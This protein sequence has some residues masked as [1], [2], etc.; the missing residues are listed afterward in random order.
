MVFTKIFNKSD[1]VQLKK[2]VIWVGSHVRPI[3]LKVTDSIED[4]KNIQFR[5]MKNEKYN[6]ITITEI[7]VFKQ[8]Y[9]NIKIN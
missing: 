3:I 1:E 2:W 4:A 9:P 5:L 7:E 8:K 6:S